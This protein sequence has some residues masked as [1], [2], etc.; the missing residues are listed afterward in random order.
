RLMLQALCGA[1]LCVLLLT[2]ANLGNLL[3][4][5]ATARERELAVRVAVGAGR[6]R[7]V[8][9][10]MTEGIALA[11]IGGVAGLP[12]SLLVFPLLSLMIPETLPIGIAPALNLRLLGL[13]ALFTLLTGVGFGTLPAIYSSWQATGGVL[14]SRWGKGREVSRSAL[15]A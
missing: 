5:R 3:L 6:G 9:Q 1:S 11:L 4:A 15:V 13:T 8:G 10:L 12:L 14:R 2:C 7:L